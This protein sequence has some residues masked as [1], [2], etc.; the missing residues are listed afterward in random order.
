M[1]AARRSALWG[2]PEVFCSLR[3]LPVLTHSGLEAGGIRGTTLWMRPTASVRLGAGE[4]HHLGQPLGFFGNVFC[5]AA[6]RTYK[7][8]DTEVD[9]PC[10]EFGIGKRR[11]DLPVEPLDDV[12]RRIPWCAECL[13]AGHGRSNLDRVCKERVTPLIQ[14][15]HKIRLGMDCPTFAI[16]PFSSVGVEWKMTNVIIASLLPMVD[17]Q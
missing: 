17:R 8:K 14:R 16:T 15:P 1:L 3:D 5:E 4:L 7:W 11:V 10:P 13:P 12:S 9:E 2:K 6:R